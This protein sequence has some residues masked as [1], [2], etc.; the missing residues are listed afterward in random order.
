MKLEQVARRQTPGVTR[1]DGRSKK[2]LVEQRAHNRNHEER[3]LT[4]FVGSIALF[5]QWLRDVSTLSSCTVPSDR[6]TQSSPS[7][8]STE[9][10][11]GAMFENIWNWIVS[12][13]WKC[14]KRGS[15]RRMCPVS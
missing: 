15:K 11:L 6:V 2:Q 3:K 12:T 13:G 9:M 10:D 7:D 4:G 1:R 5:I 8:V 14:G